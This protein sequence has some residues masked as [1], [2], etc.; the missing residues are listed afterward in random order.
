MSHAVEWPL[1]HKSWSIRPCKLPCFPWDVSLG[2][3]HSLTFVSEWTA[4]ASEG[5]SFQDHQW[6]CFYQLQILDM[7]FLCQRKNWLTR[8]LHSEFHSNCLWFSLITLA[9][10]PENKMLVPSVCLPLLSI[11]PWVLFSFL[12]IALPLPDDDYYTFQTFVDCF[13]SPFNHLVQP[14]H[15]YLAPLILLYLAAILQG[16]MLPSN[17][18]SPSWLCRNINY[19]QSQGDWSPLQPRVLQRRVQTRMMEERISPQ[20]TAWKYG[21]IQ[22]NPFC[23]YIL[24]TSFKAGKLISLAA[25]KVF[26]WEKKKNF[27]SFSDQNFLILVPNTFLWINIGGMKRLSSLL[28]PSLPG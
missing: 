26:S 10:S 25:L 19:S 24:Y 4:G 15:I 28:Q 23:F 1:T 27:H 9:L 5:K 16:K 11:K 8:L 12:S 7:F 22:K 2:L 21:E 17:N 18:P 20:F 6:D 3:M 13:K 14:G